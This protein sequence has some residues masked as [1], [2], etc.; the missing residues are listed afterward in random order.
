MAQIP[1]RSDREIG[2][3]LV[4]IG[5]GIVGAMCAHYAIGAGLRTIVIDRNAVASGTTGAGE[6]NIMVS[7]KTPG[8]E[9]DWP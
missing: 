8:P 9:L 2:A 7:D 1:S 6:G 5:A 4:I 3:D